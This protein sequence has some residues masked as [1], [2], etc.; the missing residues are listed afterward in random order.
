M[1]DMVSLCVSPG[2]VTI[3]AASVSVPAWVRRQRQVRGFGTCACW[4]GDWR[5]QAG[6]ERGRP[7]VPWEGWSPQM[8]SR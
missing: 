8:P 4:W 6:G 1:A 2:K 5:R 3:L 7:W